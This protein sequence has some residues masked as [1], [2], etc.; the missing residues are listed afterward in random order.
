LPEI[1]KRI[2]FFPE[3]RRRTHRES[4]AREFLGRRISE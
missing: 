4:I 3:C 2:L 1:L